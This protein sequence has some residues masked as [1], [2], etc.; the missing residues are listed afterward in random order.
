MLRASLTGHTTLTREEVLKFV[1]DIKRV[2]VTDFAPGYTP[3]GGIPVVWFSIF[4]NPGYSVGRAT[5]NPLSS[6]DRRV[7]ISNVSGVPFY[8]FVPHPNAL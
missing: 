4:G 7:E 8:V 5:P 3:R 1:T 6:A 2:K